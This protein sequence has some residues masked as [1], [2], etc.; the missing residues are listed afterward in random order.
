MANGYVYGVLE[1]GKNGL[2]ISTNGGLSHLTFQTG[3]FANY[4]Y[5]NGLQ[6]NEFNTQ[7][8]YKSPS[9]IF[10][11]G[12]IKGFN[13]FQRQV[14]NDEVIR[15]FAAITKI[16]TGNRVFVRDSAF[17]SN[18]QMNL[19][20]DNND[21]NFHLAALEFTK[22]EANK[23]QYILEGWDAGWVTTS[24]KVVRYSNLLPGQY[25]FRMKAAN[26]EG[27]WSKEEKL[28]L[29]I[30]APYWK[31]TPF[32]L[33]VSFLLTLTI[34]SITYWIAQQKTKAKLQLLE[35]RLAVDAERNRISA[36]MHDEIGSGI[37]HIALLGE[38]MQKQE[39]PGE[40]INKNVRTITDSARML[41]HTMSEIIWALSPQ[42]ETLENLL[43]YI[44][45][46]SQQ[47]F[48]PFDTMLSIDF[49]DEVPSLKLTNAERRNLYLVT[50]EL[51][52]NALKH[53]KATSVHLSLSITEKVFCFTVAD[54]GKGVDKEFRSGGNG[55]QNLKKR[56]QD[57]R[58]TIEW[59]PGKPGTIVKFCL[60]R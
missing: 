4:T 37:M 33:V 14:K 38:Q 15:P 52:G 35:K 6:S 45:E 24:S 25:T 31:R 13:W 42:N 60:F 55:I 41:V 40:A 1:D 28:F 56:M 10:F 26:A 3:R 22:P 46:Q 2:W 59:L 19:A 9:G 48:E 20:H 21:V 23:I 17:A 49:P 53:A 50:K 36:D 34:V 30:Q 16:E 8:F 39:K 7:A 47:Y 29:L 12:G 51:L 5:H 58:G 11:F 57:I 44:R 32:L 27:V 18:A 43:A 54:N